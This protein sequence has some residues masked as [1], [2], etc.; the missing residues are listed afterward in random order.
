MIN[1]QSS[2]DLTMKVKDLL[3]LAKE[4]GYLTYDGLH[5]ALPDT[6]TTPADLDQVLTKLRN[7][8]IDIIEAAD[9]KARRLIYGFGFAGKEHLALAERLLAIPPKERFDH[10][11]VDKLNYSHVHHLKHL[12]RLAKRVRT[13]DQMADANF[14]AWQHATKNTGAATSSPLMPRGGFG[15]PSRAV[16]PIRP[17]LSIFRFT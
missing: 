1:R 14:A 15:R 3:R 10:V 7:L 13:L 4:Q 6:V 9:E 12:R 8:D 11:I 17:A 5:E 16:S 2:L